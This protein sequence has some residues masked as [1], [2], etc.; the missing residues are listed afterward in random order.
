VSLFNRLFSRNRRYDDISVSIQ[1][2]IDERADELMEEGMSRE[3]AE[4]AA[5]REF[6]NVTVL[7]ER[8]REVWQ[9]QRIE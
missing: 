3:G 5:R 1:E 8:S 2:H 6:G 4:R 9:W 7:R